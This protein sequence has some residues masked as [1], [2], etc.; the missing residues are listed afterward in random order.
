MSK[1]KL[2]QGR[3]ASGFFDVYLNW[4]YSQMVWLF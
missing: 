4:H 1:G 2:F 3:E